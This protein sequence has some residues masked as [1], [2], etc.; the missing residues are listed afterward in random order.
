[1]SQ[2]LAPFYLVAPTIEEIRAKGGTLTVAVYVNQEEARRATVRAA[3]ATGKPRILMAATQFAN[4]AISQA[5][6]VAQVEGIVGPDGDT[7]PTAVLT[8][9]HH[10]PEEWAAETRPLG[11]FELGIDTTSG[12][13]KLGDGVSLWAALPVLDTGGFG[14]RIE[15]EEARATAAEA[16]LDVAK[17]DKTWVTNTFATQ[18]A[19]GDNVTN[20]IHALGLDAVVAQINAAQVW[21]SPANGA[22]APSFR[23]LVASDIP[24]LSYSS[25]SNRP[26]TVGGFGIT[27][28]YTRAETD[29]AIQAALGVITASAPAQLDTFVEVYNRFVSDESTAAAL[30]ATVA[31]KLTASNNLSDLAN[32]GAARANLG[33]GGFALLSSLAFA[34][35]TALPTT[36]AGYGIADV[37]T[38]AQSD[39]RYDAVGTA[40]GTLAAAI[41]SS[42]QAHSAF[43]DSLSSASATRAVL[44]LPTVTTAGRLGRFTDTAGAIGQTSGLFED[45]SGNVGVGTTTPLR[46][47]DINLGG[48]T[49]GIGGY[50]GQT[51]AIF[52]NT[53]NSGSNARLSLTAGN[54]GASLIDFGDTDNDQGGVQYQHATDRMDLVAGGAA[55]LS[56]ASANGGRVGVN[57][58]SP[59]TV[60]DINGSALRIRNSA[61]PASAGATG[62]AGEIRWDS[63]YVYA[64]VATNTWKRAALST[65]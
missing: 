45:A 21:A 51:A 25:L 15:A 37:Y 17:A 61:T 64:C 29:S 50:A 32:P 35:L 49:Y 19:F 65:W 62:N 54:A 23:P 48:S 27:D 13:M 40:S 7:D 22:G 44:A 10:E 31:G 52:R 16:A 39:A 5:M 12:Q 46:L 38:K 41:G 3:V 36:V 58:T 42:V 18:A 57:T 33:L 9:V 11:R 63:D 56:I 53:A 47:L 2:P 30:N 20:V 26:T 24:S 4:S 1:M 34:S 6:Q 59:T 43:L 28:V 55:R 14:E 60:L 8:L